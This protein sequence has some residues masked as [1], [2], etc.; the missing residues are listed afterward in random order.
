MHIFTSNFR[1]SVYLSN[2]LS[3]TIESGEG[4]NSESVNF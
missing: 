4:G 3:V 1:H 2:N